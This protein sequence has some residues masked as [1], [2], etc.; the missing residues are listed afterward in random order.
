MTTAAYIT[1]AQM[2]TQAVSHFLR[3]HDRTSFRKIAY[4]LFARREYREGIPDLPRDITW[5][6]LSDEAF[7]DVLMQLPVRDIFCGDA[8]TAVPPLPGRLSRSGSDSIAAET[9]MPKTLEVYAIRYIRDIV[10]QMHTHNYFEVNYVFS[11]KAHMI[12]ENETREL[13]AGE[14]CIIAPHSRHDLTVT[15]KSVAV[16]LMLRQST[17]ETTFFTL[18]AQE[19]LLASF[20][21]GILYSRTGNANYMLFSTD[22]SPEIKAAFKDIFMESQLLDPYSSSCIISR[23]QLLFSLMLRRYGDS[24][25]FY[26]HQK[27]PAEHTNI[28]RLL[29]Y[30]QTHARTVTLSS[31][32][33]TF[34]YNPSYLSRLIRTV[35]GRTLTQILTACKIQKASGLLIQTNLNIEDVARAVGYDSVDHFSRQFKKY[36]GMPPREYRRRQDVT[37]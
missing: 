15:D 27:N 25:R 23:V 37:P 3:Y 10:E 24:I 11:G 26:E 19:D 29:Q 14:L 32:A 33:D 34:G 1:Y 28:I 18:L 36:C 31:L 5:S 22:N 13:N 21:R 16:S 30:I 2:E 7:F 12:F 17:F 20:F 4:D 35:T 9:I 8:D 6:T